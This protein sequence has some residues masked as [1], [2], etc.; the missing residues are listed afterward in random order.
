MKLSE[1]DN[2][3]RK[4]AKVF[5]TISHPRHRHSKSNRYQILRSLS[6]GWLE[7]QTRIAWQASL[8]EFRE[9]I[10]IIPA[11]SKF[12]RYPPPV[13]KGLQLFDRFLQFCVLG[14]QQSHL[15]VLQRIGTN[16][17]TP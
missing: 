12:H 4:I 2:P 5:F 15:F 6:G 16:C 1:I 13:M 14:L 3:I 17:Q 11:V 8:H 9:E 10:G 7:W